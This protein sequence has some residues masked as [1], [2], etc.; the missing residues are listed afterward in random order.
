MLLRFTSFGVLGVAI[1]S[2]ALAQ[3][4]LCGATNPDGDAAALTEYVKRLE[5]RVAELERERQWPLD[6]V[7]TQSSSALEDAI[8]SINLTGC[9]EFLYSYNLR[10]GGETAGRRGDTIGFNQ[11]RAG[12]EDEN[13]FN[14]RT[15]ELIA[16]KPLTTL[17]ST[18]FK[19]ALHYG[20][21]ARIE[22]ADRNFDGGGTTDAF[23]VPEAFMTWRA[24]FAPTDHVDLTVGKF[25]TWFGWETFES[26]ANWQVTRNPIAVYGTPVTHTG[27]RAVAPLGDKIEGGLAFVNG[28]DEVRDANDGKTGIARL[29]FGRYDDA[30]SSQVQILASYGAVE[31]AGVHQ[32][33]KRRLFEVIWDGK[34]SEKTEF[35]LDAIWGDMAGRDWHGAA[36]YVRHRC[37]DKVWVSGR[38]GWY[39]DDALGTGGARVIDGTIVLG[40]D[41]AIDLTVALEYRHDFSRSDGTYLGSSG[42]PVDEQDTLTA[43]FLCRF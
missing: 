5:S 30:L 6:A 38:A 37:T 8:R 29:A 11:L 32:G 21:G 10:H 16:E 31:G 24:P 18:G 3:D 35:A 33:D 15:L 28:W 1:G 36:A 4:A 34:L 43:S 39:A 19:V 25:R 12:D 41:I 23:A 22:D 14:F 27:L 9:M 17:G 7:R 20:N 2:S 40:Y 26:S 13:G 42:S